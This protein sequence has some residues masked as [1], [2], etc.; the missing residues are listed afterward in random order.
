MSTGKFMAEQ[1]EAQITGTIF[2]GGVHCFEQIDSTNMAAM[3]AGAEKYGI[4]AGSNH[5]Q[6]V[7]S[8]RAGELWLAEEQTAGKGRSGHGWESQCGLGIYM[9]VLAR[10]RVEPSDA[11]LLSLAAGLAVSDAV[12]EVTAISCD[13]RWPNDVVLGSR[14]LCGIL[15]ELSAEVAR[16]RYVVIG[17]GLNVNQRQFPPALEAIATSLRIESG[18]DFDRLELTAALL[19]ALD[20]ELAEF[21]HQPSGWKQNLLRRFEDASTYCQGAAVTVEE[22]GGYQ[23]ITRGLDERGF[24]RVETSEAMRTVLSGGV[25]KRS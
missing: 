4:S 18:R 25:R 10:P 24:L 15:T 17:L 21:D 19:L 14:K 23:G 8:R 2:A 3:R 9:S 16:V 12:R 6:P 22:Y 11:I 13:L 1:L 5:H 7:D 20:H